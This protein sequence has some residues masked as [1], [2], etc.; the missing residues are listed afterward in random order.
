MLRVTSEDRTPLAWSKTNHFTAGSGFQ[1]SRFGSR[2]VKFARHFTSQCTYHTQAVEFYLTYLSLVFTIGRTE[3]LNCPCQ[4]QQRQSSTVSYCNLD[5][6]G[7]LRWRCSLLGRA[8]TVIKRAIRELYCE[9]NLDSRIVAEDER[10]LSVQVL[11][12]L[13]LCSIQVWAS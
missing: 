13:N 6:Y 12:L 4:F 1:G 10:S 9:S 2:S 7:A 3:E 8:S 5:G 11:V